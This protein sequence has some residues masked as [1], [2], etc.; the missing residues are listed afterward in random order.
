MHCDRHPPAA[1]F[2]KRND[3]T[4]EVLSA[5]FKGEHAAAKVGTV[6]AKNTDRQ[7]YSESTRKSRRK[8][9]LLLKHGTFTGREL[10]LR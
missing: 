1:V 10:Q 5:L 6:G 9:I 2:L 3:G 7:K 4:D 8:S